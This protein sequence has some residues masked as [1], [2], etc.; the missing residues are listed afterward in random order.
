MVEGVDDRR[1]LPGRWARFRGKTVW[2]C[3][4]VVAVTVAVTVSATASAAPA[5]S[6]WIVF[7]AVRPGLKVD[8]LFRIRPSGAGLRQLTTGKLQSIAPAFSPDGKR[9]AF[10]RVGAG[11]FAMN[12]DG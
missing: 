3:G 10:A 5:P 2:L 11:I 7:P 1:E 6:G 9:I 8:Q 12:S 4:L